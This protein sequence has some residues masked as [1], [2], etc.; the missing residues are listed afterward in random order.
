[1]TATDAIVRAD[2]IGGSDIAAIVGLS[3]WASPWSCWAEKVGLVQPTHDEATQDRL[4]AGTDAELYLAAQFMRHE[5]LALAGE[6]MELR[7][8]EMTWARGHCDALVFDGAQH[9]EAPGIGLALG[10]WEAKTDRQFAPWAEVPPYYLCQIQWYMALSGLDRWWVTVGFGGWRTKT[11][12]VERDQSDIDYITARAEA[13]WTNHVLTGDPPPADGHPA[14]TT[15]LGQAW[16]DA[17]D[18]T[19]FADADLVAL[20][21][22]ALAIR[23]VADDVKADQAR[24]DNAIRAALGDCS[25]LMGDDGRVLATWKPSTR[26]TIDTKALRAAEPDVAERY[27]TETSTRS[28]LI[29]PPKEK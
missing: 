12:L 22:Q 9:D 23:A 16:P 15:A 1:M 3:P 4:D 28:L 10:G 13:F 25:T 11:Y 17:D 19:L 20:W 18:D 8:P 5:G 21:D 6:Q 2:F 7:H 27:M 29:K 14:T 24:I 26:R